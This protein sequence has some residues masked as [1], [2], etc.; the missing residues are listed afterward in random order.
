MTPCKQRHNAHRLSS[1]A[2][3][4]KG[5]AQM[6]GVARRSQVFCRRFFAPAEPPEQAACETLL[7]FLWSAPGCSPVRILPLVPPVCACVGVA[8]AS[9]T[10]LARCH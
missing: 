1:A 8:A 4:R 5:S 3:S 6:L 10:S 9:H 7:T 2:R